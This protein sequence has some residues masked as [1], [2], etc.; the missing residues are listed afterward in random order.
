MW[1]NI[2]YGIVIFA[3]LAMTVRE[4]VWSNTLTLISIILVWP[5][6]TSIIAGPPPLNGICITSISAIIANS[7]EAV[8]V[9]LPTPA[10]AKA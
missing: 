2:F 9:K 5:P 7:T 1:Y 8:C 4:G 10:C 3:G 6:M